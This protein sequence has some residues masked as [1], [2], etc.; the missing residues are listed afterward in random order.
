M[1]SN[2]CLLLLVASYSTRSRVA[3]NASEMRYQMFI[4]KAKRQNVRDVMNDIQYSFV[5]DVRN[6]IICKHIIF[7]INR[8]E[9]LNYYHNSCF[10]LR[11]DD[12]KIKFVV[13]RRA[14]VSDIEQ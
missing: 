1:H 5:E 3:I 13:G 4:L 9:K 10:C 2:R 11:I 7:F 6:N 12:A 8:N 14:T